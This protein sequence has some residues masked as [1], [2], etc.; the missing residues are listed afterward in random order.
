MRIQF[1]LAILITMLLPVTFAFSQRPA[2]SAVA[3]NKPK[4]ELEAF[5]EKYGSV[6]VKGFSE[7][8]TISGTGGGLQFTVME[9]RNPAA[10]SKVKGLLAEI[11]TGERYSSAVRSFIEYGEI[12]S[13]IKGIEY[14]SKIDKSVTTLQNFEARYA[15]KGDFDVTT[16]NNSQGSVRVA[17]TVGRYGSKSIYLDQ[18]QLA[19]LLQQLQQ[20]KTMLDAL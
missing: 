5:Q 13:L 4:T 8:P 2:A 19:S 20:A 16:F 6:V 17:V 3:D 18:S 12:D 14:V 10:N 7:L 11:N 15:T 9:L 1:A